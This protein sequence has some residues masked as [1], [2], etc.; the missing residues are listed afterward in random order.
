MEPQT[1]YELGLG[2][3]MHLQPCEGVCEGIEA[4]DGHHQIHHYAV[5]RVEQQD[6]SRSYC[7][8]R[9]AD[10]RATDERALAPNLERD[11]SIHTSE[12]VEQKSLS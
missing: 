1:Y 5:L 3:G 6:Q 10:Y 11:N 2:L 7:R 4:D 8:Q 9:H 12:P